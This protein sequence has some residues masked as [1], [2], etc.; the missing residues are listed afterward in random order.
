M[1]QYAMMFAHCRLLFLYRLCAE[2]PSNYFHPLGK[3]R[4]AMVSILQY[5]LVLYVLFHLQRD[6]AKMVVLLLEHLE[7]F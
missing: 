7:E 4:G 2:T 1:Q 5:P 6:L 3:L